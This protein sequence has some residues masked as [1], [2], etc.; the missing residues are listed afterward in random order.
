MV[1]RS[2]QL[3][4]FKHTTA[5]E[6]GCRV[7][8]ETNHSLR[9]PAPGERWNW[10]TRTAAHGQFVYELAWDR[11]QAV[12]GALLPG[13]IDP[14]Q[15]GYD[16]DRSGPDG[17]RSGGCRPPVGARSAP[18]RPAPNGMDPSNGGRSSRSAAEPARDHGSGSSS[19]A[20]EP[21]AVAA[22]AGG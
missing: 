17:D 5:S 13:L 21:V 7:A 11:D 19:L 18:G 9:K 20:A 10:C 16:S 3:T 1:V 12:D 22:G 6:R 8:T 2:T 15:H 14:D 4:S